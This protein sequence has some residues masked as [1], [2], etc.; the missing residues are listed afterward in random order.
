MSGMVYCMSPPHMLHE[1]LVDPVHTLICIAF[2]V[3]ACVIFS[4]RS[5]RRKG[6]MYKGLKC[7]VPTAA[8]LSGAILSLLSIVADF[9]GAIGGGTG[10]LLAVTTIYSRLRVARAMAAMVN[11]LPRW[12]RRT[13]GVVTTPRRKRLCPTA[14]NRLHGLH[15]LSST[16][17][18]YHA[19]LRI[20]ASR[21]ADRRSQLGASPGVLDAGNQTWSG[22]VR[23][24]LV[25]DTT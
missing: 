19:L 10:I 17:S 6:S 9:I 23:R 14:D 20:A 18:D 4:K 8:V 1:A 12:Q 22:Q 7:V 3:T 16:P 11:G 13:S 15:P 24:V 2:M 5:S 25:G 21:S